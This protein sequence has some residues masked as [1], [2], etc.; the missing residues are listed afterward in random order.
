MVLYL[1]LVFSTGAAVPSDDAAVVVVV[2]VVAAA[3]VATVFAVTAGV[4]AGGAGDGDRLASPLEAP[5]YAVPHKRAADERW[6]EGQPKNNEKKKKKNSPLA[7]E[8]LLLATATVKGHS[9]PAA[10]YSPFSPFNSFIF[11]RKF[12]WKKKIS[13]FA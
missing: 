1:C 8:I 2:V 7:T 5:P 3:G 11:E 13:S 10:L 6:E 4:S 9:S 12:L